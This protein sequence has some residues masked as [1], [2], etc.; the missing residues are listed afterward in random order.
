MRLF[1][2]ISGSNK[3][4]QKVKMAAPVLTKIIPGQ[5]PTCET[6]FEIKFF[7]PFKFQLGMYICKHIVCN[8]GLGLVYIYMFFDIKFLTNSSFN[9]NP[10]FCINVVYM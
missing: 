7:T 9:P 4:N 8:E 6:S 1:K 10:K 3:Q 5:G 2:Y